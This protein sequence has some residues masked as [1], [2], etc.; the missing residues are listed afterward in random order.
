MAD[1]REAQPDEDTETT[2]YFNLLTFGLFFSYATTIGENLTYF[3][4]NVR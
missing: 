3:L 2:K 1:G 4:S